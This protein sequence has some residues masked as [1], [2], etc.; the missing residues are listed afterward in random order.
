MGVSADKFVIDLPLGRPVTINAERK[1]SRWDR[2]ATTKLWREASA[3]FA[4][5]DKSLPRPYSGPISIGVRPMYR[6]ARS[7]P[8]VGGVLPSA[9]ATIDGFVDAGVL[10]D[11]GPKWVVALIFLTPQLS[12][13]DGL[14]IHLFESAD[15]WL[16]L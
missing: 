2:A 13:F 14:R 1:G 3:V 7:W 11:D 16:D 8:D 15:D 4:L 12:T 5:G 10:V 6:T 9:K